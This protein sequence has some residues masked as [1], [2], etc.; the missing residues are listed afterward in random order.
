MNLKRELTFDTGIG[1]STAGLWFSLLWPEEGSV[2]PFSSE[3]PSSCY[4]LCPKVLS[5]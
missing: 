3:I 4:L 2:T 5:L 1:I